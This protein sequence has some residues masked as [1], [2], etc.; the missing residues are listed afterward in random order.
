ML[1]TLSNRSGDLGVYVSGKDRVTT[2]FSRNFERERDKE[3][4]GCT[5]QPGMQ[6]PWLHVPDAIF[7]ASR[8]RLSSRIRDS[9]LYATRFQS[10]TLQSL[11]SLAEARCASHWRALSNGTL[12][13][14][15]LPKPIG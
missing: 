6:D 8:R 4:R 7:S 14:R 13:G 11:C 5:F 2:G 3:A 10:S 15:R 12:V 9:S 1:E